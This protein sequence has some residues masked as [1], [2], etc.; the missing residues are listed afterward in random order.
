MMRFVTIVLLAVVL[1]GCGV[2]MPPP[3]TKKVT[4]ADIAGTWRYAGQYP[5][6]GAEI[7]FHTNGIFTLVFRFKQPGAAFTNSGTWSLTG[8]AA[9]ELKPFWTSSVDGQKQLDRRESVSW[10]VTSWYN[11]RLAPFGGDS[12]DPD[13]WA[14]LSRVPK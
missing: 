7:T 1:A 6:D 14:V 3:T 2:G 11:S 4:E 13:M 10:W 8:N 12:L 5:Q 9:L